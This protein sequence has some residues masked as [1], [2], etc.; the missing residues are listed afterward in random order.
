LEQISK[1]RL[2]KE[3]PEWRT[4]S[5]AGNWWLEQTKQ[6]KLLLQ[7]D[8]ELRASLHKLA[9]V[10]VLNR[11]ANAVMAEKQ[12]H[13]W[14]CEESG[15]DTGAWR[16]RKMAGPFCLRK[17]VADAIRSAKVTLQK[18]VKILLYKKCPLLRPH[19][20]YI[21]REQSE[22]QLAQEVLAAS[23]QAQARPRTSGSRP[24]LYHVHV[25][26]TAGLHAPAAMGG[27]SYI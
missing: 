5:K 6:R 11:M 14:A 24:A 9:A 4:L 17:Q 22:R 25:N 12:A 18:I 26:A 21:Y 15:L 13:E 10:D 27:L 1:D 8:P 7:L 19:L 2:D 3:M 20:L 16:S 23:A